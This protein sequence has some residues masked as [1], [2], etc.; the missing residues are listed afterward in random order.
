MPWPPTDPSF[1]TA[2]EAGYLAE[3]R[4]GADVHE[5]A[6]AAAIHH[7]D[8]TNGGLRY[9]ALD[10]ATRTELVARLRRFD[11]SRQ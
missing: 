9:R 4:R 6:L 11:V 3:V 7:A 1:V 8:P 10:D 5:D 2:I